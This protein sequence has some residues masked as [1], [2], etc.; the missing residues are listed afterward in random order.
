MDRRAL[1]VGWDAAT[2]THVDRYDP[3]WFDGL[4][5]GGTLLPE[6]FWQSREVD[7]GSAWTTLTTGLPTAEHGVAM[8][9][10]MID[11]RR[12]FQAFS[13][14]DRL[15]P[16]N[17]RGRPARIW[18][19]RQVLGDQPTN[20]DIPY[21]RVWHYVPDS[22]AVAV[23][24]TDPP[25]P[26]TGVT[27]S[28]FP[29]PE[30]GVRP[31]SLEEWVR[32]R[33]DGEPS[34]FDDDG[35]LREDYIEDLFR[36]HEAERDLVLDLVEREQFRLQFVVFTLLD[37]LLHVT[38]DPALIE[39]AYRTIDRTTA[40]LVEAIDPDDVLVISDHGMRHDPRGKWIHVH[41]ERTGL[42]AG[43]RPWN[44]ETHLDVTP[45]LVEYSG[46]SMD[47]RAYAVPERSTE[48]GGMTAQLRDLGY[49]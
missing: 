36:T 45:T 34:K 46:R 23:P 44:L 27:V 33:Y 24:L 5:H 48:S 43:T 8:L 29:S 26:T 25:K 1:V 9:S 12:R 38:D 22:L 7:S 20:D 15:I 32:D 21:K 31:E 3:A 28:G 41:D 4:D 42:W 11:G 37:R 14:I 30:V 47:E 6:P 10:G 2:T 13:A 35:N 18:A 49:L 40:T 39:R 19:R 16:R 17:L